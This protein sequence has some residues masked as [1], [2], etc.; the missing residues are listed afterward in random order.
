MFCL[1]CLTLM[2]H[3]EKVGK[4]LHTDGD[5]GKVE[6]NVSEPMNI[7]YIYYYIQIFGTKQTNIICLSLMSVILF[8]LICIG[9]STA[10]SN[11]KMNRIIQHN[12][13]KANFCSRII[14]LNYGTNHV[15]GYSI[16]SQ[17]GV[18][19]LSWLPNLPLMQFFFPDR[20]LHI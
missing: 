18:D 16:V 3:F 20:V 15:S 19:S 1:V 7:A 6:N 10:Y 17:I 8:S 12:K 13:Y 5:G 14:S 9:W 2:S 11:R 4:I